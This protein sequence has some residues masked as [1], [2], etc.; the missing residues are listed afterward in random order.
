VEYAV[1]GQSEALFR[2]LSGETGEIRKTTS[3]IIVDVSAEI[4]SGHLPNAS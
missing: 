4:R 3:I 2:N 1:V